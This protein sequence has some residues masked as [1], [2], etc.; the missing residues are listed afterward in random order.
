MK[1]HRL[2]SPEIQRTQF[3]LMLAWACTIHKVQGLTLNR[4]VFSFQLF[5]HKFFNY[6]QVY[7]A[8]SRVKALNGLFLLGEIDLKCI[9]AD[10]KVTEEYERL[11]SMEEL[12]FNFQCIP[13]NDVD[14]SNIVFTVID[15]RSLKK[16]AVD[17]ELDTKITS[18]DI[19]ALTETRMKPTESIEL[20]NFHVKRFDNSNEILSLAIATNTAH[21][22]C[23]DGN[24]LYFPS[25]NGVIANVRKREQCVKFLLLYRPKHFHKLQFC[26]N[27]E[28]IIMCN[29]V[30]I[31]VGD[32]NI[33]YLNE[34]NS[35]ELKQS[36]VRSGYT[37]IVKKPTFISAGSLLDH[38]YIKND[39]IN[40]LKCTKCFFKSIYYSDH[41]AVQ[42]YLK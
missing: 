24:V 36:M 20:K 32:F 3:P 27:I 8:L 5:K 22:T 34:S 41:D 18:S 23:L 14:E 15:I 11:R 10:P 33:N 12:P 2:S 30:D 6:G 19:F 17:I 29:N 37:Q 21:G 40:T 42:F 13:C 39:V 16:H 38:V 25:V 31:I 26:I 1:Q 4:V 28:Q 7:V 9:R 35:I